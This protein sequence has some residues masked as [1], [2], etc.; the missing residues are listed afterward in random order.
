MIIT[1]VETYS[2]RIHQTVSRTKICHPLMGQPGEMLVELNA[3]SLVPY[4]LDKR[5]VV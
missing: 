2:R 5:R 1:T 4:G 3:R